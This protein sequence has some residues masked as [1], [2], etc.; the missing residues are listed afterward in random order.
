MI[1]DQKTTEKYETLERL[2]NG[3]KV[4]SLKPIIE[5]LKEGIKNDKEFYNFLLAKY[6]P[7]VI[8]TDTIGYRELLLV[9]WMGKIYP[10]WTTGHSNKT[11]PCFSKPP[12]PF[13][14]IHNGKVYGA[15][16]KNQY[17]DQDKFEG[18]STIEQFK[19]R[20]KELQQEAEDYIEALSF[21]SEHKTIENAT[22]SEI[23]KPETTIKAQTLF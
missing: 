13:A 15:E 17:W 1:I 22:S 19:Q 12:I 16:G 14:T 2:I 4:E 5:Y 7:V 6:P 9:E 10:C 23:V 20:I 3:E 8:L 11:V 18:V 21:N